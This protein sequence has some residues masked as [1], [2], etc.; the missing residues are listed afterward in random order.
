MN[1]VILLGRLGKDPEEV[2]YFQSGTAYTSFS[3]ATSES[4]KDKATGERQEKTEWHNIS[5]MGKNA[6]ICS[7]WL[8]KGS[9]VLV[10]GSIKYEN[11]ENEK[12]KHYITKIKAETV[13]FVGDKKETVG[14]KRETKQVAPEETYDDIPF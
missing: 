9:Q 7:K 14:E 8:R 2:K 12:G 5:V 11:F 1:K 3:L 10:E 13:S 4:W 6:E